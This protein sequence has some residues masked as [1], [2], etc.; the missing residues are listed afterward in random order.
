MRF[1]AWYPL[2]AAGDLSPE[3]EGVLQLRL[4]TGLVDYPHGKSAMVWYQHARELRT[5]AR[6]LAVRF[7]D[8]DLVCRHLIDV[9]AAVDLAAFC[10][11][12]REDFE[13]RFGR[14][15]ELEP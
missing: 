2:S 4:A 6:A 12:L 13:R 11:K 8:K 7:A 15:P 1:G 14:V 10:A 3:G 5:A 9:D